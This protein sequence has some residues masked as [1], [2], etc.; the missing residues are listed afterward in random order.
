MKPQII[1]KDRRNNGDA[2]KKPTQFW[3]IGFQ[4]KFNLVFESL[5]Y[6]ETKTW[7]GLSAKERSEIHPQYANRFIRQYLI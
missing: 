4:P 2:L 1:N 6:V 7:S 3:F 5:D